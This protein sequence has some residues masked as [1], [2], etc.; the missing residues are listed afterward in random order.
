MAYISVYKANETVRVKRMHSIAQ[1]RAGAFRSSSY[2]QGVSWNSGQVR[3]SGGSWTN[4]TSGITNENGS[5][6]AKGGIVNWYETSPFVAEDS[7]KID[8]R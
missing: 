1:A 5:N 6:P 4:W 2:I 7:I 3:T 8:L